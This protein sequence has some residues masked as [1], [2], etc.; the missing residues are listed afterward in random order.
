MRSL[1][2]ESGDAARRIEVGIRL[3]QARVGL[4]DRAGAESVLEETLALARSE[5]DPVQLAAAVLAWST[6]RE[7]IGVSDLEC[8][9][10]IDAALV[11]LPEEDSALRARLLS[12]LSSGLHLIRGAEDRHR[13]LA[14]EALAMARRLGDVST[15]A[16]VQI[17][18]LTLLTGPDLLEERFAAIDAM[19]ES[20][21]G[22]AIGEL[23]ALSMK[24]DACAEAG[25]RAGLDLALE[26]FDEKAEATR[27]PY[28]RWLGTSHRAALALMEGRFEDAEELVIRAL[29]QGQH[30]QSRTPGLHFAQQMFMLR[31]W[32]DRM[33]EVAPLVEGGAETA[34]IVPAW[35][36]ALANLYEYLDRRVEA[37]REFDSVARDDFAALPRDTTWRTSMMLLGAVCSRFGDRTNGEVLYRLLL[38]HAGHLA[39]ASPM[40]VALGPVDM[41]L[42]QLAIL[43]G[44][45][46]DAAR[47]LQQA[48]A[49]AEAMRALPWQAE[50]RYHRGRLHRAL[51]QPGDA[52]R[53]AACFDA[54][55]AIASS[56]GMALLLRWT[57]EA[58]SE[59]TAAAAPKATT[60]AAFAAR[61]ARDGDGFTLVFEGRTTRLRAMVGLGYIHSLL[62]ESD[63]ELHVL[64]LARSGSPGTG[65]AAGDAGPHLDERARAAYRERARELRSELALAESMGD[66]GRRERVTAELEFLTSELERAF[67]LGGRER[68]SG[69]AAERARVSV[70][71]AIRYATRKIAEHDPALAEHLERSIRT[72][73]FCVYAPAARDPID[74]SL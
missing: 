31:G 13:A 5:S 46:D 47:H 3:G 63:R 73:T 37:R 58:R 71:R 40:I 30:A 68:R 26:A 4:G 19:L 34:R 21:A 49:M 17:R 55:E 74:W 48:E 7:E 28:F 70:T 56:I 67:G 15:L 50:I 52:D 65:S 61:F 27:H 38:P 14:T 36:C 44:R 32:Q 51:G 11:A 42:G 35:R 41:R 43:L 6:A 25:D 29:R 18:S 8:N 12:R 22:Y 39:V 16:F 45:Y 69:A 54:A 53:A 24:A 62:A 59:P 33:Q 20:C 66:L 64:D 2:P 72:G 1:L 23:N 60:D 9:R 57:R 10:W